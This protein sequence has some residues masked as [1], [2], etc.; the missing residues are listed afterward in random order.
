M[1]KKQKKKLVDIGL[2][3]SWHEFKSPCFL[4]NQVLA[5]RAWY[6][7]CVLFCCLRSCD[8]LTWVSVRLISPIVK[9]VADREVG[10]IDINICRYSCTLRPSLLVRLKPY[11]SPDVVIDCPPSMLFLSIYIRLYSLVLYTFI[12]VSHQQYSATHSGREEIVCMIT[13]VC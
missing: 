10:E 4:G 6:C 9:Q 5:G 2:T 3:L 12:N 13:V 7:I 11:V 1:L 8:F